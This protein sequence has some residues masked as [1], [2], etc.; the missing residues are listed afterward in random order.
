[1]KNSSSGLMREKIAKS[2]TGKKG[3]IATFAP[4]KDKK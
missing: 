3:A 2:M 4:T 1:M